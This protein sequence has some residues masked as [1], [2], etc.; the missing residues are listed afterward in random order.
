M[1]DG[2]SGTVPPALGIKCGLSG[3]LAP[4][5]CARRGALVP[6]DTWR[7]KVAPTPGKLL[8]QIP[9]KVCPLPGHAW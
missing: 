6:A 3:P 4:R 8:V 9:V 7:Q 1:G 2:D 5:G